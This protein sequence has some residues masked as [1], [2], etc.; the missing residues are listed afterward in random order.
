MR[1]SDERQH[2]ANETR[3]QE[4]EK[5]RQE[6]RQQAR[7]MRDKKRAEV[8]S[9]KLAGRAKAR[10]WREYE[11]QELWDEARLLKKMKTHKISEQQFAKL[12]GEDKILDAIKK[13]KRPKDS[14]GDEEGPP[15]KQ[16]KGQPNAKRAQ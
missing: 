13:R 11:V 5:K 2:W 14:E 8:K 9:M 16:R 7:T 15:Q 10:Q 6:E 12:T 3:K 1:I 4:E